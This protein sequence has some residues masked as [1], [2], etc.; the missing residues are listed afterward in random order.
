MSGILGQIRV[1]TKML[2]MVLV[3]IFS[4][5]G[6]EALSLNQLW[7]D[8]NEERK[9]MLHDLTDTAFSLVQRQQKLVQ[10]GSKSEEAGMEEALANLRSLRYANDEY[11][12]VLDTNHK[13]L[14]HPNKKIDG[15]NVASLADP[16]GTL[17]MQE[18][19]SA[20]K[21]KGEGFV[22]Y[23]WSRSA[24]SEPVPKL[25]YARYQPEWKWVIATGV[26]TDDILEDF[27]DEFWHAVGSLFAVLAVVG[28]M[29]V[30]IT[31]AMV[32][33][34]EALT[35]VLTKTSKTHDLTLRADASNRDE[36][37]QMGH[38]FNEMMTSFH[39]LILELTSA[40]SQV[41]SSAAELSTT[42]E[43]T[44]KGMAQQQDE[45]TLV[46]TAM[47][48][49]NATVHEVTQNTQKTANAAHEA[50]NAS[51]VGKD[52]VDES[53]TAVKALSDRL[54][55]SAEL[56]QT[57]EAESANIADILGV[58][59]NIAAQTNL[60][61]LNAAIEAARAGDQGRGFAVVADEVRSLSSRTAESTQKIA[62]VIDR[63]QAKTK[64]AVNAMT[65]S[66]TEADEVVEQTMKAG[67]SLS[68]ISTAISQIDTM[69][70]QIA[71]AS[72]EQS[73]VAEDINRNVVSIS[74][75]SEESALGARQIA[76]SCDEL[77]RL[78]E[79]LKEVSE[80]FTV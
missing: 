76:Q 37:G 2:L 6:I 43:Q 39:D 20:A 36:F 80:R 35:N 15:T 69:S 53:I 9:V 5:M 55:N 10:S 4:L 78:A 24:N 33:P 7:Y 59:N 56:T 66:S 74:S 12:F 22:K 48:E 32:N 26:Y 42:T 70:I 17:L 73:A 57:L 61:A 31:R 49:M 21:A 3:S 51:R 60:L 77:A 50:A 65:T 38:A 68:H 19:V 54:S 13:L 23:Y 44:S 41:A 14:M 46:A 40:T 11:F 62:V 72:E 67:V 79:H 16:K 75:V 52:V 29:S 8:L 27:W 63:L 30:L 28:T 47:T 18:L 45:T 34:V 64:E 71:S 25:S 58:I 1:R